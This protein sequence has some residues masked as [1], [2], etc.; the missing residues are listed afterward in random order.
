MLISLK[1]YHWAREAC[2]DKAL[3]AASRPPLA[4]SMLSPLEKCFMLKEAAGTVSQP[5]HF[6][7]ILLGAFWSFK[8]FWYRGHADIDDLGRLLTAIQNDFRLG[9]SL[10]KPLCLLSDNNRKGFFCGTFSSM[11]RGTPT[12]N[13]RKIFSASKSVLL[14]GKIIDGDLR[15]A[16]WKYSNVLSDHFPQAFFSSFLFSFLIRWRI[17]FKSFENKR[18]I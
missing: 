16:N 3:L 17:D 18:K 9:F 12:D 7:Y 15:A 10:H 11:E 5:V 14:A 8:I 6:G 4:A 2:F 13:N 1:C